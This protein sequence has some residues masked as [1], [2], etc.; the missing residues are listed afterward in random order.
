MH[1]GHFILQCSNV[2]T[3]TISKVTNTILPSQFQFKPLVRNITGINWRETVTYYSWSLNARNN[4]VFCLFMEI[5]G[6]NSQTAI[7]ETGINTYIGLFRS[8]PFKSVITGSRG[9]ITIDVR[10]IIIITYSQ[11][12]GS[13]NWYI[14][15]ITAQWCS[16]TILSP[17]GTEL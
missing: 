13:T 12:P 14:P 15:F 10:E 17:T 11:M 6:C 2:G 1:L 9:S 5:I 3:D 8:F 16:R 7:Q 4:Q